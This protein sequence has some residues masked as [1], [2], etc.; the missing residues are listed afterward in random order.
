MLAPILESKPTLRQWAKKTRAALDLP[1]LSE[2]LCGRLV[3]LPE[4]RRAENVLLYAAM[5][6]ELDVLSLARTPE[7]RFFL[8]R[9]AEKRRLAIHE[10]PCDLVTSAWGIREPDAESPESSPETLDLVL[11]PGLA[12]T[13][14]GDRLGYGG[15]FYDR[16]LPKLR[17]GCAAV[18]VCPDE[19]V[20]EKLPVDSWDFPMEILVTPAEIFRGGV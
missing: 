7:K 5:P 3:T 19:L 8:P 12:F 13:L 6:D 18:G 14:S 17:S 9:C 16:F 10:F 20:L 4:F 2:K 11:V 15:G 1:A